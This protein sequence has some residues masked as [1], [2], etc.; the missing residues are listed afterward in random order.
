MGNRPFNQYYDERIE[1]SGS[2]P[3]EGDFYLIERTGVVN[4][5]TFGLTGALASFEDDSTVTTIATV[6]TWTD[7]ANTLI[8]EVTTPTVVFAANQFTYVAANSI[9]P[10]AIRAAISCMKTEAS[11]MDYKLVITINGTPV[12][13][14]M[15]V[16]VDDTGRSFLSATWYRALQQNDIISLQVKNIGGNHDLMITDCQLSVG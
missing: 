6:D 5:T 2:P 1:A 3:P 7:I 16:S 9:A 12:I 8:E 14:S 13:S 4:K 15:S 10:I 11:A